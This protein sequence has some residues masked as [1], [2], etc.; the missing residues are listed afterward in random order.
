MVIKD[1]KTRQLSGICKAVL[2]LTTPSKYR[3]DVWVRGRLL[4]LI[5]YKTLHCKDNF[6]LST[7]TFKKGYSHDEKITEKK[8]TFANRVGI[9]KLNAT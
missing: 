1:F 3:C 8:G 7:E 6:N 2:L 5:I 4:A 9:G